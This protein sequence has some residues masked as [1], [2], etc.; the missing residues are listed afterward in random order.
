MPAM[1]QSRND[2]KGKKK[3]IG[4]P[5]GG[6]GTAGEP[7]RIRDYPKLNVTIKP[8]TK[9]L[10]RATSMIEGRSDWLIVDDAIT[11]YI[12][13]MSV[14]DRRAIEGLAKRVAEKASQDSQD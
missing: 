1:E 12:E 6:S 2:G 5:P 3:R 14:A 7:E 13:Q 4:R 9:A 11:K 8:V 10:L